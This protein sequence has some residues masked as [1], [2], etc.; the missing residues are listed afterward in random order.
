VPAYKPCSSPTNQHGAPLSFGSCGPPVQAS[1]FLTIGTPPQ[2]P[3]GS[4]GSITTTVS[5]GDVQF[6]VSIT[7]VRRKTTL[8]DYTGELETRFGL[9]ITDKNNIAM[10]GGTTSTATT[11]DS[12][13]S[14][15]V[16]CAGTPDSTVGSTCSV[17]TSANTLAPGA[18]AAGQRAV[19][20]LGQLNVY[21]GGSDGLASTTGDNTPFMD[22]GVFVP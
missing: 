16:P 12:P 3:A 11:Q 22:Q 2:D 4:I 20:Q 1:D 6:A 5:P 17:I 9:R 13:F 18:V 15:A 19:W 8:V 10:P 14:Y 21:D 7:D